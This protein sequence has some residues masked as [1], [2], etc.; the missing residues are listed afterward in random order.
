M[1]CVPPV[2]A[3]FTQALI[4]ILPSGLGMLV[5]PSGA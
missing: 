1:S 5:T 3:S 4:V 2:E